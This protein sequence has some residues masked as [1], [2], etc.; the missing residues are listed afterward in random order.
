[1]GSLE[2]NTSGGS[3]AYRASKAAVNQVAKSL[4]MDLRAEG[5]TVVLLH[6]GALNFFASPKAAPPESDSCMRVL[7][8]AAAGF[9][10]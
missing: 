9:H 3:Y 1:M 5:I 2:D 7:V 6:P 10:P 8:Y 4:S